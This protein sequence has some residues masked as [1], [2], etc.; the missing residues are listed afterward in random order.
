MSRHDLVSAQTSN[1]RITRHA[2]LNAIAYIVCVK[3]LFVMSLP[4][5]SRRL[6]QWERKGWN[7][8][9]WVGISTQRVKTAWLCVGLAVKIPP[10]G[11]CTNG[12]GKRSSHLTMQCSSAIY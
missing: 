1:V 4:A 12:R 6:V 5:I 8:G 11:H 3:Q 2:A 9:R 7:W 10:Y